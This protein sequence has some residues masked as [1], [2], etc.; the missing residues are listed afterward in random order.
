MCARHGAAPARSR[1]AGKLTES[2]Q[3]ETPQAY[4]A[5][6]AICCQ[7]DGAAGAVRSV[8]RPK[9]LQRSN[10]DE[11]QQNVRCG[12]DISSSRIHR[13][14][15]RVEDQCPAAFRQ[16]LDFQQLGWQLKHNE[17]IDTG[18]SF[19]SAPREVGALAAVGLTVPEDRARSTCTW[20][21]LLSN[22][23]AAP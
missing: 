10:A 15:G 7:A 9:C 21:S 14:N 6:Y 22:V 17:R 23:L 13:A 2:A 8:L 12:P 19:H 20:S 4:S 16:R 11:P 5:R 18:H 3:A 1:R